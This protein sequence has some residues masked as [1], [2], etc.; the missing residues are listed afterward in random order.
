MAG[1]VTLTRDIIQFHPQVRPT[2]LVRGSTLLKNFQVIFVPRSDRWTDC[3]GY[4]WIRARVHGF[5]VS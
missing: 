1:R 5:S 4:G 2:D 3:S